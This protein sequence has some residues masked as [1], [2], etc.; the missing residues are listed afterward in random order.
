MTKLCSAASFKSTPHYS[1]LN[2][3]YV[4]DRQL[5]HNIVKIQ[6]DIFG[7][8]SVSELQSFP[9]LAT[10]LPGFCPRLARAYRDRKVMTVCE[11]EFCLNCKQDVIFFIKA[12]KRLSVNTAQFCT[13]KYSLNKV[14]VARSCSKLLEK[15]R[16]SMR[17][18][19]LNMTNR[20]SIT[21]AFI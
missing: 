10:R 17:V 3:T 14:E 12:Q 15:E 13:I 9:T 18:V 16:S 1:S 8:S 5:L 20:T 2:F 4:E 19:Q 21:P 11:F 6:L 7:Y